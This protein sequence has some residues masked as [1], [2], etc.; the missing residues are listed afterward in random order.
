MYDD[1]FCF[2]PCREV[3]YWLGQRLRRIWNRLRQLLG[4][5][6][7][8]PSPSDKA[9]HEKMEVY[10]EQVEKTILQDNDFF[11]LFGHMARSIDEEDKEK[12]PK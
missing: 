12:N 10:N 5:Q 9:L 11:A 8:E 2:K 7:P 1:D 6:E 3:Q 4:K